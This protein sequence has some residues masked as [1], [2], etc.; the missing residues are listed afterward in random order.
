MSSENPYASPRSDAPPVMM[1]AGVV[2][3]TSPGPW[4]RRGRVVAARGMAF[5]DRCVKCNRPTGG[6]TLR[7]KLA[8]HPSWV[9]LFVFFGILI[10]FIVAVV[11]R[12]TMTV[13]P[14]ICPAHR[15]RHRILLAVGLL[16]I[17][18]S[19]TVPIL[20]GNF[21]GADWGLLVLSG[22]M[23]TLFASVFTILATRFV[24]PAKIDDEYAW[25]KTTG[26]EFRQSLPEWPGE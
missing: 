22:V 1:Q 6:Q 12:K 14:G 23:A 19:I 10:Y 24:S 3:P 11:L 15:K 21:T 16:C 4:R 25:I 5:P 13:F 17:F 8:W 9:F 7:R 26:L 18:L 20:L 2:R